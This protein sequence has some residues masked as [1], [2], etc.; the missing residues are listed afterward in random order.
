MPDP[1]TGITAG[2]GL[3]SSNRSRQSADAASDR[4][5]NEQRAMAAAAQDAAKFRAVG[6]T[7]PYGTPTMNVNEAGELQNLG[8]ELTPEMQER[9]NLFGQLGTGA[10]NQFQIDPMQVAADRTAQIQ[11]LQQPGRDFQQ[12]R[13]FSN[14]AS[15]GLLGLATDQGYGNAVNPYAA[16]MQQEFAQRDAQTAIESMDLARD[17]Q[18]RDLNL[19]NTL[20]GQQQGLFDLGQD[21][22]FRAYDLADMERQRQ[23]NAATQQANFGQSMSEIQANA[24]TARANENAQLFGNLTSG[25]QNYKPQINS[26]FSNSMGSLGALF[27]T[28]YDTKPL[29]QQSRM[30]AEQDFGLF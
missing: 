3:Y 22:M 11:A 25:L 10:L 24:A 8:F 28:R 16:A 13:M 6:V 15:K 20:F 7:S 12:E 2:V 26:G 4:Q 29:S 19:A 1:V 9:A 27:G 18:V 21:Q 5:I 30:L 17:Q 23:I 14:L